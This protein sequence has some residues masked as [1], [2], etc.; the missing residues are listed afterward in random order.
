MKPN[1]T[2]FNWRRK[3][4]WRHFAPCFRIPARRSCVGNMSLLR[5]IH[6]EVLNPQTEYLAPLPI[7][8]GSLIRRA[9]YYLHKNDRC[10]ASGQTCFSA[11]V[12]LGRSR[13]C[14]LA[15]VLR[16]SLSHF[17]MRRCSASNCSK[18]LNKIYTITISNK[19]KN[20]HTDTVNFNDGLDFGNGL[21]INSSHTAGWCTVQIHIFTVYLYRSFTIDIFL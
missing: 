9:F 6:R 11:E 8:W 19:N 21:L 18:D 17:V 10:P 16:T 5:R 20:K 14:H 2:V 15:S 4:K 7:L 3:Y 13:Y 12:V 1:D